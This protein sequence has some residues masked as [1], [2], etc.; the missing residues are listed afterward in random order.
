MGKYGIT[1]PQI[2][3]WSFYQFA[4]YCDEKVETVIDGVKNGNNPYK[5]R[6]YMCNLYLDTEQEA[7]SYIQQLLSLYSASLNFSGSQLYITY[8]NPVKEEEIVMCFTNSNIHEDGFNYSSTPVTSRIT[9][10]TVDYLD[11]RDNYMRKS[12][13]VEDVRY[14][15]EHG[16]SHIKIPGIGITRKGEAHRLAWQKILTQQLEREIIEFKAGLQASYLKIGDVIDITDNN[17]N[18]KHYGGSV[19]EVIDSKNIKIDIPTTAINDVNSIKLS[20][21][22]SQHATWT[23][24]KSYIV[25]DKVFDPIDFSLY[26]CVNSV[27]SSTEP[28]RDINNWSLFTSSQEPQYQEYTID[29]TN[30]FQITFIEDIDSNIKAGCS[31]LS[32]LSGSI[33]PSKPYRIK[34]ITESEEL[35]FNIIAVEY[36]AEKYEFVDQASSDSSVTLPSHSDPTGPDGNDIDINS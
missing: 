4:Q 28:S 1:E 16:Y 10:V 29:T 33:S 20:F 32:S 2:N 15:A 14:I 18:H 35:I 27:N 13:Y 19:M 9:A 5:E 17:K 36:V 23:S 12:E 25:D 7:Y 6:R 8:D 3:K 22:N 11:E 24:N 26:I 34:S 31:W 30:G 21:P